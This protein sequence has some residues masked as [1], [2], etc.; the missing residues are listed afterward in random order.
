MG[1]ATS[2][3]SEELA[4][5]SIG[6][7][8]KVELSLRVRSILDDVI[9]SGDLAQGTRRLVTLLRGRDYSIAAS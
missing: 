2:H 9:A 3:S 5:V 8:G 4:P 6:Q 7:R 1:V